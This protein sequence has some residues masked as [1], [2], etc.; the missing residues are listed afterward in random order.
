MTP[1][2]F[3]RCRAREEAAWA[4]LFAAYARRVFRWAV[5]R[6]LRAPEA[7]DAAQ[8]VLA[9]AH[10]SIAKCA[11]A[12]AFDSWLYQ[13]TRRVVANARRLV[14]WRRVLPS[15]HPIEPAFEGPRP[16]REVELAVRACL[17]KLPDAQ[18]E[19]LMLSDIE[20]YTREEV[21]EMVG[22]APGTVA[23]RVRLGRLAFKRLWAEQA[24]EGVPVRSR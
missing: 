1:E 24:P 4:E 10:R 22:V 12:R 6:G 2:L 3:E 5:M 8:E 14:W 7:E 18:A 13:I 20:G 19:V 15:A 9:T 17:S 16:G 11:N 21:A 23:S